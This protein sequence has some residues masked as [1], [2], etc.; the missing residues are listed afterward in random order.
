MIN[1]YANWIHQTHE[2]WMKL[3]YYGQVMACKE[4]VRSGKQNLGVLL[5]GTTFLRCRRQ[6]SSNIRIIAMGVQQAQPTVKSLFRN[7]GWPSSCT[8][9]APKDFGIHRCRTCSWWASEDFLDTTGR[10]FQSPEWTRSVFQSHLG[11]LLR[12]LGGQPPVTTPPCGLQISPCST[13]TLAPCRLNY[14]GNSVSAGGPGM[15]P[16]G[17]E[18]AFRGDDRSEESILLCHHY[19]HAALASRAFSS[20]PRLIFI[21]GCC[22]RLFNIPLRPVCK[23]FSG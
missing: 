8:E 4:K 16:D 12:R 13:T 14:L 18:G 19:V 11:G 10:L 17:Y 1:S 3:S 5:L 20:I 6:W 9:S 15:D 23:A 2:S 21:S 7:Y 22:G